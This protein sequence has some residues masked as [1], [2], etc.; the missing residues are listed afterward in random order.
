MPE[1]SHSF[2]QVRDP[3]WLRERLEV[4]AR[5]EGG[6]LVI[7]LAQRDAGHAFPT[8]DLFRR[9]EV[10]AE[11]AGRRELHHLARH[12]EMWPGSRGRQLASDN[13]VLDEP[14]TID[15]DLLCRAGG[16]WWVRYQRVAQAFDGRNPE[17][18]RV[19]SEILLSSGTFPEGVNHP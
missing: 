2:A 4:R 10:G 16:S 9:L 3:A 18:A 5:C 11:L 17:A 8:G 1:G 7:E 12:F 14:V 13:R 6:R 15:F 19:E